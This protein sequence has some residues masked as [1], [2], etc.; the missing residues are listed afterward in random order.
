MKQ[1]GYR[2]PLQRWKHVG[3][4]LQG[5]DSS[6]RMYPLLSQAVSEG[7]INKIC[8]RMPLRLP[9]ICSGQDNYSHCYVERTDKVLKHLRQYGYFSGLVYL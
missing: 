8:R 7:H 3:W 2:T 9:F 6:D 4:S 5:E 1:F